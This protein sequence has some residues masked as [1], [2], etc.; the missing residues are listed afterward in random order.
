[1]A[2]LTG[3]IHD[4]AS[5]DV[6]AGITSNVDAA[7][8]AASGLRYLGMAIRESKSV[9]AVATVK[10]YNGATVGGGTEIDVVELAA[11]ASTEHWFWPGIDAAN[12]ISIEVIAGEVDVDV[13]HVTV[14]P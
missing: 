4:A 8:A 11:D 1:M 3:T 5:V 7:V 10:I 9:A 14:N 2:V 12:G 6:N 13:F